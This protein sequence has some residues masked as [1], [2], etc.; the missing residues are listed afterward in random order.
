M[1]GVHE[2]PP[3][4]AFVPIGH[5]RVRGTF[6]GRFVVIDV[7]PGADEDE[8]AATLRAAFAAGRG[9]PI[10]AGGWAEV[11]AVAA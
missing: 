9:R 3:G 11:P 8:I 2:L 7:P 10:P 1:R 5:G 4:L 6:D